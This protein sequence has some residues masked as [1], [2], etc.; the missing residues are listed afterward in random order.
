[1]GKWA[2]YTKW[3]QKS[4]LKDATFQGWVKE[5]KDDNKKAY[6]KVCEVHLRAQE[7]DLR[8]H[9]E[10]TKHKRNMTKISGKQ[11]S[12]TASLT[13]K[14]KI[15]D[16][17]I[18]LAVYV[19]CH[20]S[21]R[22]IDHLTDFVKSYL[23]SASSSET[24]RRHRTK[25]TC[26][27]KRVISPS[28]FQSLV[29]DL[30]NT[31]FTIMV[32]ESTDVACSK[33]LCICIKYF[34]SRSNEITYQFLGLIPVINTNAD[35]LYEHVKAFFD[36]S[37]IDLKL[38]F[39]LG[40]DGASNL[41]G[42]NLSLYTLIK[43]DNPDLILIKYACHAAT[44]WLARS[45]SVKRILEQWCSLKTHF[46]M[47][48]S[49]C[50]KY[51][52]R[53]L[54]GMYRDP[55]NELYLTFLKPILCDFE[56]V[57]LLFQQESAVQSRLIHEL[58]NFTLLMLRRVFYPEYVKLAVDWNFSSIL[59]PL[60]RVDFGYEFS[61]LLPEKMAA[62]ALSENNCI[63]VE[64]RCRKFLIQACKQLL[65][66]LPQ[67][68][69]LFKKI[70]NLSP[71]LCLS[72]MRP[73]FANLPLALADQSKL[74]EI[75]SQWRLLLTLNWEQIFEGSIPTDGAVFWK[76]AITVK[77]AGGDGVLKDL[78]QFALK[79]YS[80]PISNAVVERIFS[81]VGS[82]KTKLLYRVEWG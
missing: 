37:G 23:P 57:N 4:W 68:L 72:H 51:A 79:V 41:C 64:E 48:S 25:C 32:D 55:S 29:K 38:C 75:E 8:K 24:I 66:R 19:A 62:K 22:S 15:C 46:Q 11:R 70:Q 40:T 78:A 39:G 69:D 76:K 67:N 21:I 44:R 45:A 28:L 58:G 74:T 42:C 56:R 18:K 60:E 31:P 65:F 17:E 43:K 9:S 30:K 50:D 36:E 34:N 54:A 53:E 73:A 63:V 6:C 82:V 47:A 81:R 27:I 2:Q 71:S 35:A 12:I 33:H 49:T 10:T 1:M 80:L 13:R 77:N 3:F 7:C 14:E 61:S 20:S 26:I 16:L 59:L 52:A 5:V